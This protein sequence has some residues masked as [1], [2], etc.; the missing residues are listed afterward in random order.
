MIDWVPVAFVVFKLLILGTC[1]FLAVKWH[2][3]QGRKGADK[4][5]LLRAGGKVVAIFV[6]VLV[7]LG[8]G[9]FALAR[10]LGMDLNWP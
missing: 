5:A 7:V 4:R 9:T 8:V 6:L 2:Y 3:D 10:M 1:M